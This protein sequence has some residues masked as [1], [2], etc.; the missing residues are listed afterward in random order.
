MTRCPSY[1]RGPGWRSICNRAA[2]DRA[3]G[4]SSLCIARGA[5]A[6]V[7]LA[8]QLVTAVRSLCF[9]DDR[10]AQHAAESTFRL[11][12]FRRLAALALS[13]S[14][15][16][17]TQLSSGAA[18]HPAIEGKIKGTR[19]SLSESIT[20][21]TWQCGVQFCTRRRCSWKVSQVQSSQWHRAIAQPRHRTIACRGA[22][23]D[24]S[25]VRCARP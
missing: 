3:S 19:T 9:R 24:R 18:L 12:V 6:A 15:I 10:H 17:A 25:I 7:S 14:C 5:L 11:Q 1:T 23:F 22:R 21:S 4:P 16:F 20:K 8:G 2:S 13:R